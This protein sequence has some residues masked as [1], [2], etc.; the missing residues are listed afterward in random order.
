MF[1]DGHK[2]HTTLQLSVKSEEVGIL[3]YLL[4]P[5]TTH[6]LQ[7]ADIGPFKALKHYWREEVHNKHRQDP[8]NSVKRRDVAPTISN[9]LKKTTKESIINGFKRTGLFPLNVEAVDFTKCVDIIPR[10]PTSDENIYIVSNYSNKEY[11]N[12]LKIFES[13]LGQEKIA[14]NSAE[15]VTMSKDLYDLY[16]SIAKKPST[17]SMESLSPPSSTIE[18]SSLSSFANRQCMPSTSVI[19]TST[20]STAPANRQCMPSTSAMDQQEFCTTK[21]TS[22]HNKSKKIDKLTSKQ[23]S[24]HK[25]TTKEFIFKVQK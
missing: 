2:S 22:K 1:V 20:S 21:T 3:I 11:K 6:L 9:V 4:P 18:L 14:Q 19:D 10:D 16:F 15:R 7:P 17:S 12:A 24:Y 8:N 25:Y 5:N 13:E 23:D